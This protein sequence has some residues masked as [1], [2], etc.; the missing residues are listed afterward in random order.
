M[1]AR[2]GCRS[3]TGL[4]DSFGMLEYMQATTEQQAFPART[5]VTRLASRWAMYTCENFSQI[6]GWQCTRAPD[7]SLF[8]SSPVLLREGTPLGFFLSFEDNVAH[9]N[10]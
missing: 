2:M 10:D 3:P 1:S 6:S 8:I 5:Q 4:D 9:F 7:E